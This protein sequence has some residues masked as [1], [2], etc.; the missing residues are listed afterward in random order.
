M[1]EQGT[2]ARPYAQ[3][4]FEVASA[5]GRL[6]AWSALLGTAAGV[7]MQPEVGRLLGAP[8]ID[9]ERLALLVAAACRQAGGAAAPLLEGDAAPGANLLRLLA[10][11]GRLATLPDIAARFE[12]LKAEAQNILDVTLSSPVPVSAEQQARVAAAL[13]QR[14]G[15]KVR[16]GVE[17]DE[18][19]I[20][21]ARLKVGDRVIDG[22]VRNRLEKLA[23]ALR[24]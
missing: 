1:A 11:N 8:G 12:V 3:A 6:D 17:I 2:V 4:I 7:V 23:T 18:R 21:G 20:G 22:S 5:D 16:L 15:R 13:E 10:E 14:F 9:R 24:V 19:L